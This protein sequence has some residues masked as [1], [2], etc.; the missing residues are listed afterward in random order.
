M[1]DAI[2]IWREALKE[3]QHPRHQAVWLLFSEGSD[4]KSAARLLADHQAEVIP[5]LLEILD[6]P[7]LYDKG[8][9]GSGL[10]PANAVGV[11]GKWQVLE[12]VP[13]LLHILETED[14]ETLVYDHTAT[15]LEAMGTGALEPLLAFAEACN[16]EDLHVTLASILS[17]IGK[18]DERVYRWVLKVFNQQKRD[19]AVEFMA[20]NLLAADAA[21]AIPYL[22][23]CLQ[24]RK[25]ARR[26]R[27]ILQRRIEEARRR[28][29]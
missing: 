12:A 27:A 14:P 4:P 8:S 21:R 26:T 3:A 7:A 18:G 29:L 23:A 5:W 1:D 9:F 2:A 17:Q 19:H 15:A 28:D 6:T 13:R 16:E 10:A 25:Y 11:L 22:E 20:E 24:K